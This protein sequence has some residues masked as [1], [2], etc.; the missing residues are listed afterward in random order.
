MPDGAEGIPVE[1]RQEAELLR[2]IDVQ[3][4]TELLEKQQ[5][6][7]SSEH[8]D[9][10]TRVR[11]R[12]EAGAAE[13]RASPDSAED[14]SRKPADEKSGEAGVPSNPANPARGAAASSRE[15]ERERRWREAEAVVQQAQGRLEVDSGVADKRAEEAEIQRRSSEGPHGGRDFQ[16]LGR[17][18][19]QEAEMAQGEA[20]LDRAL[21]DKRREEAELEERVA[22]ENESRWA[23]ERAAEQERREAQMRRERVLAEA[24]ARRQAG[25]QQQK[26]LRREAE[27]ER[28]V[29]EAR[30]EE[31]IQ[32][33]AALRREAAL[34][35]EVEVRREAELQREVELRR[36][37]ELQR[38]VEL[39]RE[40][41]LERGMVQA[42]DE[43]LQKE[44][45]L[46]RQRQD[47]RWEAQWRQ[48]AE[49]AIRRAGGGAD[50]ADFSNNAW[51]SQMNTTGEYLRR[52]QELVERQELEEAIDRQPVSH[53]AQLLREALEQEPAYQ[54]RPDLQLLWER[55]MAGSNN[56]QEPDSSLS[57]ERVNMLAD[58]MRDPTQHL[59]H[60]FLR[61][62]QEQ[63]QQDMQRAVA[64]RQSVRQQ[65]EEEH[66]EDRAARERELRRQEARRQQL[67]LSSEEESNG[68]YG[69]ILLQRER[70]RL[71]RREIRTQRK[72]QGKSP[73]PSPS[74]SPSKLSQPKSS[75]GPAR[76]GD[77]TTETLYSIPEDTSRDASPRKSRSPHRPQ[78]HNRRSDVIDP[79]MDKLRQRISQQREKIGRERSKEI[80]RQLKL[81]KLKALLSAKRTGL[82]DNAAI[83]AHLASISSTSA[84]SD[85]DSATLLS[86]VG[87]VFSDNTTTT[88]DSSMEM[89]LARLARVPV[90]GRERDRA[91]YQ[92]TDLCLDTDHF[93]PLQE[94][95][96]SQTETDDS[97]QLGRRCH[98]IRGGL[99]GLR[100]RLSPTSQLSKHGGKFMKLHQMYSPYKRQ[101][102]V[103]P[104]VAS[105]K[106]RRVESP[107][108]RVG[109]DGK[110]DAAT[111]YPSP[112]QPSPSRYARHRGLRLVSQG[113]QTSPDGCSGQRRPRSFSPPHQDQPVMPVPLMTRGQ[114]VQ[115]QGGRSLSPQA[116]RGSMLV[117]RQSRV[118]KQSRQ[119]RS[120]SPAFDS[121]Q[122]AAC[123]S[124]DRSRPR[125]ASPARS[126][127]HR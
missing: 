36:E 66:E 90:A 109:H 57:S 12:Q 59:V 58:L 87:S 62:R 34:Q 33:E 49:E 17:R 81:D 10:A 122:V 28:E 30:R 71:R 88:K 4:E 80:Q 106:T 50:S 125:S 112:K 79:H 9:G 25:L 85:D 124:P 1:D 19:D 99:S 2:A 23:T 14:L 118:D 40:A 24:E 53:R 48:E 100:K 119:S 93:T 55:Y 95:S 29:A 22:R 31:E 5:A 82:L 68:S 47:P 101:E 116:K 69:E 97:Y 78:P 104:T 77:N 127:R 75:S 13:A 16:T 46:S 73:S 65:Q 117:P 105:R 123:L 27:M 92:G 15:T 74:P 54:G 20:E 7:S 113:V 102:F 3:V 70:D 111:M 108:G 44:L 91:A 45:E 86:Q 8:S 42:T 84:P 63:H 83:A 39:R 41:E 120:I 51:N 72:K 67:R 18:A 61:Q 110:R 76:G 26:E 114:R 60:T 38:E 6:G 52:G 32:R 98:S 35:R 11:P 96:S 103:Q 126:D 89:K 121:S 107:L 37:A 94:D 64:Q 43:A 56:G 115:T 21:V